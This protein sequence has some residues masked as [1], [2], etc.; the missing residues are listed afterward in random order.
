MFER[1][2]QNV[3]LAE[4]T[5][6]QLGGPARWF[7][8]ATSVADLKTTLEFARAE[9]LR[10]FVLGG[11]SNVIIPEHGWDGLG[12]RIGLRGIQKTDSA[13]SA[14]LQV[15]A[16]EDW[17]SFVRWAVRQK[18]S[19]VECLSGIPGTVGATPVQN[20]GAYGQEVADTIQVVHALDREDLKE[21]VFRADE[22]AFAY[23]NRRFKAEDRDRYIITR[24]D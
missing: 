24:E 8:E 17:D 18:L 11:G 14:L 4:Y 16:G 12:V 7:H 22:C 9:K 3:P 21:R 15:G 2:R 1:F 5:T 20:V 13:G 10:V 19:G 6:L 23:R